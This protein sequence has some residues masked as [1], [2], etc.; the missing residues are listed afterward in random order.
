MR[1]KYV[2]FDR[3]GDN[4]M[5]KRMIIEATEFPG[6]DIMYEKNSLV[7]PLRYKRGL[8]YTAVV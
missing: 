6:Y 5:G 7:L 2:L 3:I 4:T 1:R 8:K